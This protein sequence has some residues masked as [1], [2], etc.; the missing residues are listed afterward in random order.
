MVDY[1]ATQVTKAEILIALSHALD[2][3]E[4]QP[5]GHAARTCLI[6]SRIASALGLSE[7]QKDDV[8]FASLLKDAGCSSNAARIH[9][10][11]G[12]DDF[13]IKHGVKLV[14]WSNPIQSLKY[15]VTNTERGG[16]IG[17]KLRRMV[18]NLGTPA[19]VMDQ[20]TLARCTRGSAIAKRLG[21]SDE[22]AKAVELLDEHW[23]GKGSPY[24]LK[25][26]K[27]PLEAQIVS[28]SQTIEVFYTAYGIEAAAA[29]AKERQGSWFA[30]KL[31]D[32]FLSFA[33]DEPFWRG[34]SLHA[35]RSAQEIPV[36]AALENAAEADIDQI[37]EAFAMIVDAKSSFTAEHSSRVTD[38]AVMLAESYGFTG[39]RLTTLRRA[40]LLHD[41][42]KLGVSNRILEKPGK[43]D[44]EEFAVIRQHS[45]HSWEILKPI[46]VFKR[47]AEIASGH[48]ERLDGKGY[49]QGLSGDQLD[50]ET[51]ILAVADVYDALSAERPYRG[52]MPREKVFEILEKEAASA[53][54]ADCV[55][56]IKELTE[57]EPSLA[58]AA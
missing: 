37:C 51:R 56:R 41:I 3:V 5:A 29:M 43:L 23:D 4:G 6:S 19:Q 15:A 46:S 39:R 7:K 52:A 28:I 48:H 25:A 14:D 2:L 36:A 40:S 21:F 17:Q 13:I 50:L 27:I 20:V 9:K 1:A 24:H 8:Y 31:V 32:A 49:W 54:D 38:Y 22:A 58:M 44:D 11:F 18:S 16:T 53:L 47:E 45:K 35:D 57:A 33:K 30:P 10:I 55:Y 12:G 26:D 42:G 34:V